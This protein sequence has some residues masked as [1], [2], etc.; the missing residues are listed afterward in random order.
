VSFNASETTKD[1]VRINMVQGRNTEKSSMHYF[2]DKHC[3]GT[4]GNYACT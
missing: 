3:E 4:I 2:S 1:I